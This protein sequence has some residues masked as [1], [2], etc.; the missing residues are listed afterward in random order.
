MSY[1]R[2]AVEPTYDGFAKALHWLIVG[3]LVV[4]FLLAWTMPA[5]RRG[6][7]PETLI[8]LHLSFGIAIMSIAF[9]RLLWRLAHSVP[10]I[11]DGIP[12]WQSRIAE[13]T[14]AAL[15]LL[16]FLV[17]VLGWA[18]ASARGWKITVFGL[19]DMPPIWPAGS[20]FGRGELGGIHVWS[21]Y[22]LIGLVGL[23]VVAVLYHHLW[24]RD[25]VLSRMLP[26][27]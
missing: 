24:L 22:A 8:G 25:R 2:A 1:G 19:F 13:F 6:T 3:L 20:A 23:H 10:L 14:H 7:Q 26:S 11:A 12:R 27:G 4:Q 16:L 5:I 18:N 15:Y 9:L 17:P 21:A